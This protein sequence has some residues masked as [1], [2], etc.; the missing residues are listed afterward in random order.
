L[1]ALLAD[2]AA[3]TEV[4]L[5]HVVSGSAIG[6]LDAFAANGT[7]L[8]TASDKKIDVMIDAVTGQLVIGGTNVVISDIYTTNG[9]I[10]VID[11]VILD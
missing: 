8:T 9:V 1:S 6:S 2:T 7:M 4:L 10:H 3:L 11:T 5:T